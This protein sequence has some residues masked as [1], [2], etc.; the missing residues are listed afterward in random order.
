MNMNIIAI[1]L[2]GTWIRA[3]V[4]DAD[5]NSC[6]CIIRRKTGRDRESEEI[7]G[8]ILDIIN[9]LRKGKR[10]QGIACALATTIDSDGHLMVSDNLPSLT[11]IALD[12]VL[13]QYTSLPVR[14]FND[15]D[16]FTFR[17]WYK[18]DGKGTRNFIGITLGTGIGVGIILE[19]NLYRGSYGL[20][21]EI[22]KTPVRDSGKL[23]N[24]AREKSIEQIYRTKSGQSRSG[25][26][27]A[28]LAEQGDCS[29]ITAY[30]DFGISL[31]EIVSFIIN[32]YDPECISLGGSVAKSFRF[33]QKSL[34]MII[35]NGTIAG[36]KVRLASSFIGEEAPPHRER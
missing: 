7:I 29:A 12:C 2:G 25:T 16:A 5:S 28:K 26:M 14:I 18:G 21:G 24:L 35:A 32:L 4:V 27:I 20:A 19:G 3:T 9:I 8:D 22:W 23:E 1:D 30:A 10:I 11:G 17:E 13:E 33:F 15:A 31:G 6:G 34:S 36:D